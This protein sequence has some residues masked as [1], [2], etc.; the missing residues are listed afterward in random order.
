MANFENTLGIK[1]NLDEELSQAQVL[2]NILIAANGKT[3]LRASSSPLR[4]PE[5]GARFHAIRRAA[6]A[7]VV[8][9][10]TY[11][12][13][14]YKNSSIPIL[15]SSKSLKPK[16]TPTLL[17]ADLAPGAL[18][19]KALEKYSNPILIEGG[20]AFLTPLLEAKLIDLFFISRSPVLGDGNSFPHD[21]LEQNYTQTAIEHVGL[22]TFETWKPRT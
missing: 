16:K 10:S 11:R 17:I 3:T 13:E 7:I 14:P 2:A 4:T 20:P 1:N 6:K 15:V 5:D 21:L 19:Q 22:T 9:G 18:V 8:G 12:N